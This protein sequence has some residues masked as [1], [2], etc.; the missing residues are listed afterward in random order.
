MFKFLRSIYT[1]AFYWQFSKSCEEQNR[2]MDI[3]F[4]IVNIQNY[5][6]GWVELNTPMPKIF[7]KF[8]TIQ[9]SDI[10]IIIDISFFNSVRICFIAILIF[11]GKWGL[12]YNFVMDLYKN[13][14]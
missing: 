11:V 1:I 9:I 13:I 2:S 7:F 5:C 4:W 3:M 6:H 8:F 10:F 14:C 12:L